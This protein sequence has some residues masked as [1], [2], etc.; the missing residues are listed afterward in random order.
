MLAMEREVWQSGFA[1]IAG[2]DEVGRGPLAGPLVACAAVFAKGCPV[3]PVFDSKTLSAKKRL[4]LRKEL[5]SLPGFTYALVEVSPEEIDSLDI[6]R[7][8]HEAFRRSLRKLGSCDYALVDGLPVP[9]LPVPGRSIVKGDG[10]SASIAAASIL[11]KLAR[12]EKMTRYA[13]EFP[14]YGFEKHKGYGTKEHLESLERLG[15]CPI[16]RRSFAPVR[17]ICSGAPKQ[18]ELF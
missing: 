4:Q 6:L 18:L 3:P 17:A 11:A 13:E 2:V 15:P 16:H 8:A 9:G 5:L 7:A 12:D 1:C 14:G 10:K